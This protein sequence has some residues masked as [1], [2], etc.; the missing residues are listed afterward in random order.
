MLERTTNDL[1]CHSLT[2]SSSAASDEQV[3][4]SWLSLLDSIPDSRFSENLNG[5]MVTVF[6]SYRHTDVLI[7]SL[8][9]GSS[10]ITKGLLSEW[11][12]WG[13]IDLSV[14]Q[15]DLNMLSVI[16]VTFSSESSLCMPLCDVCKNWYEALEMLISESVMMSHAIVM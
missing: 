15:N 13:E 6:L 5:T 12:S 14:S 7:D 3:N 4:T 8:T 16:S 10:L 9:Y 2:L 1:Q 11:D